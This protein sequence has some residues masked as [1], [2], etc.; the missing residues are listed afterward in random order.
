LRLKSNCRYFRDKVQEMGFIIYGHDDSPVVPLLLYMPAKI[1]AFSREMLKRGIAVV[2][3]GFPATPI[4]ESRSRFCLSAAH[5]R[6]M[7]DKVLSSLD[8]VG[9]VLQLKYSAIHPARSL[10]ILTEGTHE[11]KKEQ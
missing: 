6:V 11:E 10:N 1:A 5:T 9:D 8:E 7:L 3:V 2:V 4:I